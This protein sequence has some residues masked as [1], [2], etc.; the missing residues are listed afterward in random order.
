MYDEAPELL[1]EIPVQKSRGG[2]QEDAYGKSRPRSKKADEHQEH[3]AK[4]DRS[5]P[6]IP[7]TYIFVFVHLAPADERTILLHVAT[8]VG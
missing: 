3:A 1:K 4:N 5:A 7:I 6:F 8:T 2:K